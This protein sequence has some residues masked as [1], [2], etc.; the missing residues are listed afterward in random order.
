MLLFVYKLCCDMAQLVECLLLGH[1]KHFLKMVP[2]NSSLGVQYFE[3][4]TK[5]RLDCISALH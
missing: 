3:D 1:I 2:V 4:R 5:D